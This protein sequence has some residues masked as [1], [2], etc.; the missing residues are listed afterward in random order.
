MGWCI[1]S[2]KQYCFPLGTHYHSCCSL[3]LESL[4]TTLHCTM[5]TTGT[6][7]TKDGCFCRC[8]S[9]HTESQYI[10]S[11]TFKTIEKN[12]ASFPVSNYMPLNQR[13]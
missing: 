8:L 13:S 10:L 2:Y 1:Y 6:H 5:D 3:Y 9:I 11:N 12:T 7:E 4:L